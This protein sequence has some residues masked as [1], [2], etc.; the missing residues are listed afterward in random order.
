MS[1]ILVPTRE[2]ALQITE[3]AESVNI[4]SL[5]ILT[6]YGGRGYEEQLKKVQGKVDIIVATPGRLLDFIDKDLVKMDNIKTV[7]FDEA[8]QMLMLG[9]RKELDELIKRLA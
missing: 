9:F 7:V 1:L 2:L 3:E 6:I 5:N 4:H 8:D